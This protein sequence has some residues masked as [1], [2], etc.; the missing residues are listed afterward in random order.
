MIEIFKEIGIVILGF[1]ITG[2]VV[3]VVYIIGVLGLN[4]IRKVKN[5]EGQ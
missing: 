2:I 5:N 3:S 1:I 4:L